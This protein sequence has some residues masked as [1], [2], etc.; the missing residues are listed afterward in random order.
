MQRLEQLDAVCCGPGAMHFGCDCLAGDGPG[1]G[2]RGGA[3]DEVTKHVYTQ[4]GDTVRL[5]RHPSSAGANGD[6]SAGHAIPAQR[7]EPW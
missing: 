2:Q 1:L 7:E 6:L 5:S 4:E 3:S